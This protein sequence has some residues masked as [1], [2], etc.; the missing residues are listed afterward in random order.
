[1][2]KRKRRNNF[3]V[4]WLWCYGKLLAQ[5]TCQSVKDQNVVVRR[6]NRVPVLPDCDCLRAHAIRQRNAFWQRQ[7][8]SALQAG[9]KQHDNRYDARDHADHQHDDQRFQKSQT[10]RQPFG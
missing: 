4:G 1:M 7:V 6:H 8:P 9:D 5:P 2:E 3:R 10:G